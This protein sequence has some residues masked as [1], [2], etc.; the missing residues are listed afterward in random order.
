MLLC[1]G[2][3]LVEHLLA[4]GFVALLVSDEISR[5]HTAMRSDLPGR[6]LSFV[7]EPYQ[8]RPRDV[9][10]I[11]S[12]LRRQLRVN[13]DDGDRIAIRHLTEDLE[14]QLEGFAGNVAE[15]GRP[16]GTPPRLIS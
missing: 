12:L 8:E 5:L 6:N 13:G 4:L 14:E 3:E 11:R 10:E 1:F 16:N 7:Q 15:I 2:R 9:Q